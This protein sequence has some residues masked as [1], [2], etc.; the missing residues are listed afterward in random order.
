MANLNICGMVWKTEGILD[1]NEQFKWFRDAAFDGVG[2]HGAAGQRPHFAGIDPDNADAAERAQIRERLSAFAVREVHASSEYTLRDDSLAEHT[3]AL[4]R[5]LD[6]AADVGASVVTVHTAL[7]ELPGGKA[8]ADWRRAMERLNE[9]AAKN[10]VLVGIENLLLW[11][12][13]TEEGFAWIAGLDLSHLGVTLDVGHMFLDGGG[14]LRPFGTI[15]E[16]VR[17]VG[18]KLVH[19]HLHDFDGTIDH[20]ELGTGNIDFDDLVRALA[21]TGY[22]GGLC[23]ELNPARI[24]P[25]GIKRSL[26]W[27][28]ERIAAAASPGTS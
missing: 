11:R 23:L 26:L 27:L 7:P 18:R 13:T 6:F 10:D 8:P 19:L 1:V 22:E 15:G 16:V 21:E 17:R 24:E 2:F 12:C 25:G 20:I 28:R 3:G 14:P 9:C 4:C 5:T